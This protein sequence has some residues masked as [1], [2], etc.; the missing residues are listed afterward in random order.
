MD[1]IVT[2][3]LMQRYIST[4]L[5]NNDYNSRVVKNVM[6]Y[7]K[8]IPYKFEEI[9]ICVRSVEAASKS[10]PKSREDHSPKGF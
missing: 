1:L 2:E 3:S 9:A 6:I 8:A 5:T 7:Q 4:H 10:L